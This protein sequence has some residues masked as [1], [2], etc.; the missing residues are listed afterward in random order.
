MPKR[1]AAK[2]KAHEQIQLFCDA[3]ERTVIEH[4]LE[5]DLADNKG[6]NIEHAESFMLYQ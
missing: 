5:V 2:T 3:D 1:L 6:I 4:E